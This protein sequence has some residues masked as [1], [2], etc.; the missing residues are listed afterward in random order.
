MTKRWAYWLLWLLDEVLD[1]LPP[2]GSCLGCRVTHGAWADEDNLPTL[3]Q[4]F[5]KARSQRVR[6]D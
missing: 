4:S 1:L 5:F 3:W 6:H 2:S